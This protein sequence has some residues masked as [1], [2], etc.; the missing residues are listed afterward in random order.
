MC[1]SL[2]KM[3]TD[4][5]SCVPRE[6]VID[7]IR[8]VVKAYDA[9]VIGGEINA[10]TESTNWDF[11]SSLF[12]AGTVITTIGT[13]TNVNLQFVTFY[14]SLHIYIVKETQTKTI[15]PRTVEPMNYQEQQ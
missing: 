9:G 5:H 13:L 1:N 2:V 12:F 8:S 7:L 3:I 14:T 11:A 6:E 10:S 15:N 4:S